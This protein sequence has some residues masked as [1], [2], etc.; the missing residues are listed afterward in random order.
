MSSAR[1]FGVALGA[2]G[3]IL[4]LG[5]G[6]SLRTAPLGPPGDRPPRVVPYPPPPARIEHVDADPGEPC[7]WRDGYYR[8]EGQRWMWV[9]GAWEVPEPGCAWSPPRGLWLPTTGRG[10]YLYTEPGWYRSDNDNKATACGA[11]RACG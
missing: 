7:V 9:D 5:C 8:W 3:A 11:A 6:S 1:N 10:E 4:A 2:L